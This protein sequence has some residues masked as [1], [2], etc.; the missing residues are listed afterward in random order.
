MGAVHAGEMLKQPNV[1]TLLVSATPF[2]V[3]GQPSYINADNNIIHWF[4][5]GEKGGSYMRL[6]DYL[7][8]IPKDAHDGANT[9]R[10]S[11]R[12]DQL[13][14]QNFP[15]GDPKKVKPA[16]RD[17]ILM[18]DYLFSFCFYGVLLW[19]KNNG[20]LKEA[21]EDGVSDGQLNEFV[22]EYQRLTGAEA[23]NCELLK[24]GWDLASIKKLHRV[25]K[26]LFVTRLGLAAAVETRRAA[27]VGQ[28]GGEEHH[29][30]TVHGIDHDDVKDGLQ[31]IMGKI[32]KKEPSSS[33]TDLIVEDLLR[34]SSG[35]SM[36]LP[37]GSTKR[38]LCGRM[39]IIRLEP[40]HMLAWPWA[41]W[42]SL[43]TAR[44]TSLHLY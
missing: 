34:S 25:G 44:L 24:E 26:K 23:G 5:A 8:T 20:H 22:E 14:D 31:S 7:L 30:K 35:E 36:E 15:N 3:L 38:V 18:A 29:R 2:N 11:I 40:V 19:D 10:P 39:T 21:K 4:Q 37:D 43:C 41:L 1:L 6:E 17:Y 32:V 42:A 33:D 13:F 12:S 28:P 27:T 9:A 16:D